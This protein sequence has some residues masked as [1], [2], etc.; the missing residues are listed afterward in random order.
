MRLRGFP[1]CLQKPLLWKIMYHTCWQHISRPHR[2]NVLLH[3]SD[4]DYLCS[5]TKYPKLQPLFRSDPCSCLS[6][7]INLRI[8]GSR[9]LNDIDNVH[10]SDTVPCIRDVLYCQSSVFCLP[11]SSSFFVSILF[12]NFNFLPLKVD[13]FA[14]GRGS[15][16]CIYDVTASM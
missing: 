9:L 2:H 4:I 12:L 7:S 11:A 16:A 6:L 13:S 10:Q 5:Q 14:R 1:C 15:R 8:R 3:R